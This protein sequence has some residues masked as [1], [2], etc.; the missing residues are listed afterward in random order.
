MTTAAEGTSEAGG[1]A[2]QGRPRSSR[3]PKGILSSWN[4][5]SL[6]LCTYSS[7]SSLCRQRDEAGDQQFSRCVYTGHVE[8][9]VLGT[10]FQYVPT[11]FSSLLLRQECE[12]T[13]CSDP[14]SNTIVLM[15]N[16][17]KAQLAQSYP[18]VS[19]TGLS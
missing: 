18:F 15:S 8:G 14:C 10:P 2:R 3:Y 12:A 1:E 11:P 13:V 16:S 4:M 19:R 6:S 9:E 5:A 7:P 17:H